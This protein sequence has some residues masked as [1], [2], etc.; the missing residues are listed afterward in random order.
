MRGQYSY[1][2]GELVWGVFFFIF[3][4]LGQLQAVGICEAVYDIA[5]QKGLKEIT[6]DLWKGQCYC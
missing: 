4:G 1:R 2:T 5:C 3:E 6:L